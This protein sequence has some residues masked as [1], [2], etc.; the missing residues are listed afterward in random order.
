MKQYRNFLPFVAIML[1]LAIGCKKTEPL[2]IPP[3]EAHFTNLTSDQYQ[4][5]GPSVAYRLPV[6]LTTIAAEDR[7]VTIAVSSPSGAVE[8]T[9]YTLST[10]T[11]TI[12]AGKAVDSITVQGVYAQYLTG[13]RDTLIFSIAQ[14]GAKA[15]DYNDTFTLIVRGPCFASDLNATTIFDFLGTY[16]DTRET[17]ASGGSPYGPYT[18]KIKNIELLT[19]TTAKVKF[20]N[21]YNDGWTDIEGTLDWTNVSAPKITI[22]RQPTGTN[23]D[24]GMP[25]DVRTNPTTPSTFN[26]CTQTINLSLDIIVNNYPSPGSAAFLSQGYKINMKR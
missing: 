16:N 17:T 13:R 25:M 11:L 7:T 26:Y 5:T 19:P 23:Y 20:E 2:S 21:L 9:H 24:T 22:V 3:E 1:L 15:S 8:G 6:G 18:A 12:P 4:V 14:P 10:K